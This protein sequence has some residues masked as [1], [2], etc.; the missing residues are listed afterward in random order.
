M[1]KRNVKLNRNSFVD[2]SQLAVGREV[3]NYGA[4]CELLK[5]KPMAGNSK[6]A[7]LKRW[8]NYFAYEKQGQ[9]FIIKEL[10]ESPLSCVDGRKLKVG[11]YA[12]Y[13]ECLLMDYLSKQNGDPILLSKINWCLRLGM[14]NDK[15][16]EYMPHQ[17]RELDNGALEVAQNDKE[18]FSPLEKIIAEKYHLS[19]GSDDISI[20]YDMSLEKLYEILNNALK[21]MQ[22]RLLIRCSKVFIIFYEDGSQRI[23]DDSEILSKEILRMQ[24]QALSAMGYEKINQVFSAHQIHRYYNEFQKRISKRN[25]SLEEDSPKW[26]RVAER[27]RIIYLRDEIREQLPISTYKLFEMTANEMCECKR[28]LNRKI[29]DSISTLADRRKT[30]YDQQHSWEQ[31]D[32]ELPNKRNYW[33]MKRHN[34]R[35]MLNTLAKENFREIQN[36]LIDYLIRVD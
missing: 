24:K 36:S 34:R 12:N 29:V 26:T 11:V 16:T 8:K 22:N 3:K 1:A 13:I 18:R 31:F 32:D 17:D 2:C 30:E 20:F 10:Y 25:A 4:L 33:A 21:S 14:M 15:F 35:F 5:E 27:T 28:E 19:L 9:K 23:V 6:T 7:Q